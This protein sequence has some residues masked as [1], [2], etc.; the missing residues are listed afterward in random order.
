MPTI[1]VRIT[2]EERRKW[3]RHG[4]ISQTIREAMEQ[5]ERDQKRRDF[6]KDLRKLQK[7]HPIHIDPDEVVRILREDRQSH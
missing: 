2:E 5:Y 4:P 1:S 7:E 3:Q 6:L